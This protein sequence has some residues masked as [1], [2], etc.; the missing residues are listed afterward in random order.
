MYKN[1]TTI[2]AYSYDFVKELFMLE[3]TNHI[4]I[5]NFNGNMVLFQLY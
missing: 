2:L 1:N 3:L 5:Y 4:G